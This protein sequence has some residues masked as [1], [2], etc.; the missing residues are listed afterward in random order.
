MSLLN[1]FKTTA[2]RHHFIIKSSSSGP[3]PSGVST[4]S[5]LPPSHPSNPLQP[6]LHYIHKSP[7]LFRPSL[8]PYILAFNQADIHA[9][10]T[11]ELT[12][13]FKRSFML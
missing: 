4:V 2:V 9:Q 11:D 8:C 5:H 7:A 6:L 13:I 1:Q 10:N 12:G 3:F